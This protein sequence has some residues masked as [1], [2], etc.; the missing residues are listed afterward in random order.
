MKKIV[1][2]I[3][4]VACSSAFAAMGILVSSE[5]TT[6]P[7]GAAGWKCTYNV[8]GRN[9]VTYTAQVCPPTMNFQ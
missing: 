7:G 6:T 3:L 5:A 1:A 9:V 8:N 2:L 4:M